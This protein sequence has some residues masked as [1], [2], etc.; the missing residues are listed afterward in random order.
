MDKPLGDQSQGLN[1]L[2]VLSAIGH[3]LK[4]YLT[5]WRNLLAHALFGVVLLV[6]A[7]WAPI[8]PWI[9]MGLILCL[10]AFNVWRMRRKKKK[11]HS[12]TKI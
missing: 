6:V 10:V 11:E 12:Q 7:I 9:K 5:D 1:I 8:D 3:G 4:A 2:S